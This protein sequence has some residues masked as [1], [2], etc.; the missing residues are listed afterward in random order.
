VDDPRRPVAVR[1][2]GLLTAAG[3][4]AV[5]GTASGL[6]VADVLLAADLFPCVDF[7]CIGP[8]LGGLVIGGGAGLLAGLAVGVHGV[9]HDRWRGLVVLCL[10]SVAPTATVV[11]ITLS[12]R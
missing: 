12:R 6:L 8:L 4:G 3:V 1:L 11:V 9:R 2:F 5:G 7:G 10:A